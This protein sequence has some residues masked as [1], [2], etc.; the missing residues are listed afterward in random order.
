V[1][2]GRQAVIGVQLGGEG[3]ADAD[4]SV[5]EVAAEQDAALPAKALRLGNAAGPDDSAVSK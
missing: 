4:G 2:F 1:L 3:R 5:G